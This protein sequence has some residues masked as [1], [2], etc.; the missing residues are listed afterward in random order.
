MTIHKS[1]REKMKKVDYDDTIFLY[2][3][4]PALLP[5]AISPKVDSST[6]RLQK[7]H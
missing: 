7:Y 1:L 3:H 4:F 2:L 5:P 6:M